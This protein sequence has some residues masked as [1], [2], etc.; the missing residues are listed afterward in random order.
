MEKSPSFVVEDCSFLY[1]GVLK[2]LSKAIEIVI[3]DCCFLYYGMLNSLSRNINIA[4]VDSCFLYCRWLNSLSR[5]FSKN[6]KKRPD[7]L[8]KYTTGQSWILFKNLRVDEN[9]HSK[10]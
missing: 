5:L 6:E 8:K 9:Q 10:Q 4:I 2:L 1:C 7:R 3:E